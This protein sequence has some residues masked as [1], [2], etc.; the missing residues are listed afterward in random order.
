MGSTE[1][2]LTSSF[3]FLGIDQPLQ[4]DTS[5]GSQSYLQDHLGSTSQLVDSLNG[6]SKAR[7]DYK[8]YGQLEGN[9]NNPQTSNPFTYTGREDDGTGLLYYRARYYDPEL[10]VFISQDPLG[11]AQRYVGENPLRFVDPLGLKADAIFISPIKDPLLY[12]N[13]QNITNTPDYQIVIH[14]N[15]KKVFVPKP[16]PEVKNGKIY[17]YDELFIDEFYE[18]YIH[19]NK[20]IKGPV[21][22]VLIACH[23]GE[24]GTNSI[25]QQLSDLSK[26]NVF[27]PPG[28]GTIPANGAYYS[29][30]T[31]RFLFNN[32][33]DLSILHGPLVKFEPNQ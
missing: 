10:E 3:P 18:K 31:P 30:N 13:A 7:Y 33:I 23:S 5:L 12:R 20:F 11:D 6:N 25:A 22:I 9:G 17:Y 21:S 29:N 14:S 1:A 26:R 28:Y 8:S 19:N 24:G 2:P 32:G 15:G 4:L 16:T 27:A